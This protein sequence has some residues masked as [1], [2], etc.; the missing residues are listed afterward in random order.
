MSRHRSEQDKCYLTN[1]KCVFI[2]V[3]SL[4]V[5]AYEKQLPVKTAH[6]PQ[7]TQPS[8]CCTQKWTICNFLVGPGV[9]R[10]ILL[11]NIVVELT[12]LF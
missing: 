1:N 4:R 6:A 2:D 3:L 12:T 5:A 9:Y 8:V 11:K 10:M 7:R